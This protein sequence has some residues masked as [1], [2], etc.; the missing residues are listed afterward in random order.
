[1][2]AATVQPYFPVDL[3]LVELTDAA[4]QVA[5]EHNHLTGALADGLVHCNSSSNINQTPILV[6]TMKYVPC[7]TCESVTATV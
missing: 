2:V 4:H 6:N 5:F 1:V 7:N 3:V